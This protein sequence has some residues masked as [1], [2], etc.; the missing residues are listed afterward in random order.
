VSGLSE[1]RPWFSVVVA[2]YNSSRFLKKIKDSLESQESPVGA[3]SIELL[4]V[5]GGSTDDTRV[6]AQSLG[7]RLIENPA[8]HAIAA[9]HIGLNSATARLVCFLD[10]DELLTSN[11]SLLDRYE[12]FQ[13]N[14]DLRAMISAGYRFDSN[15]PTSNMY[16]SEFG[17]PVS[18]ATYRCPNSERFRI[19]AFNRRLKIS[20]SGNGAVLYV[21]GSE[22]KPILCEMAAGSGVVDVDFYRVNFPHLLEDE[23]CVPHL[24]YYL[25]QSVQTDLLGVIVGDTVVHDSVDSWKTVCRK[26]SWRINNGI[27]STDIQTS[28]LS[29]RQHSDLYSPKRQLVG[30]AVYCALIFG[31]VFDAFRL[32]ITRRRIGYLSHFWLSYFVLV[33][34]IQLR[35]KRLL[36]KSTDTRYG[37]S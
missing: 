18:M 25:G 32:A 8:G 12:L 15:D 2:T 13:K 35:T 33:K 9:K 11:R 30:Y 7:F 27:N 31:P 6:L 37:G 5:D 3:G 24:Y 28:G 1:N 26:I 16:A 22:K 21:A 34:A 36:G 29:G 10:H 20:S 19:G 4:A 14:V 23:N 17:D